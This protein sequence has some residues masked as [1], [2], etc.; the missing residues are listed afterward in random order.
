MSVSSCAVDITSQGVGRC[1]E[2]FEISFNES[3]VC[4][5]NSVNA[6]E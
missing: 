6:F 2:I 3:V 1:H 5:R 4:S